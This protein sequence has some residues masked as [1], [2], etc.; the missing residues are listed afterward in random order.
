MLLTRWLPVISALCAACGVAAAPLRGASDSSAQPLVVDAKPQLH[1]E[2]ERKPIAAQ[3]EVS[4]SSAP[5]FAVNLRALS[6]SNVALKLGL[7]REDPKDDEELQVVSAG[8]P[9]TQEEEDAMIKQ[10]QQT[11][12]SQ[13]GELIGASAMS[14]AIAMVGAAIYTFFF[15]IPEVKNKDQMQSDFEGQDF[16]HGCCSCYEDPH[17]CFLS[18]CCMPCRWAD[19]VKAAGV[20][21]YWTA[22]FTILVL[23]ELPKFL[24]HFDMTLSMIAWLLSVLVLAYYRVQIRKAFALQNETTDQLKDFLMWGFCCFCAT[25]QEARQVKAAHKLQEV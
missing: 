12:W 2:A 11:A 14:L 7:I 10:A 15:A 13:V 19:T 8:G 4:Q 3:K 25:A 23:I 24:Q 18:F 1:Q 16:A 6:P 20:S 17:I 9:E 5:S 21:S 22:V